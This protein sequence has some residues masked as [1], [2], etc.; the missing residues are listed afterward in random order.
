MTDWQ[1]QDLIVVGG[2]TAG[3][4]CAITQRIPLL[5]RPGLRDWS[6]DR[7]CDRRPFRSGL[8]DWRS[9]H[10]DLRVGPHRRRDYEKR[11]HRENVSWITIFAA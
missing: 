7:W 2:G 9:W 4:A 6:I 3:M 5:A 10:V 11:C 8:G 1:E